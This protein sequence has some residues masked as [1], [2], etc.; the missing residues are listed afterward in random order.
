MQ[1]FNSKSPLNWETVEPNS[2]LA[3]DTN[4]KTRNIALTL[5]ASNR[6]DVFAAFTEDM[7]DA[8]LV[9]SG[10]ETFAIGLTSAVP[11]YLLF[12]SLDDTDIS[13]RGPAASHVVEKVDEPTFAQP[14]PQGRRN[15]D[16]DRIMRM[17]QINEKRRDEA[18]AA[19]LA[20]IKQGQQQTPAPAPAP[21]T[22]ETGTPSDA[23]QTAETPPADA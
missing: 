10:D 15:S 16:L 13:L 2:V 6:V 8:K 11:L 5:I 9:A 19:T 23:S 12:R 20:E 17:V 3:F 22:P 21:E 14:I 4:G 1:T 18:M 7:Q